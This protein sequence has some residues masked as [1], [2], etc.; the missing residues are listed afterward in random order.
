MPGPSAR[1]LASVFALGVGIAAGMTACSF[2]TDRVC[3]LEARSSL[4]VNVVDAQSGARLDSGSTVV[5]TGSGVHDSITVSAP[6]PASLP[7]ALWLESEVPAG[8]YTVSVHRAAYLDWTRSGVVIKAGECHIAAAAN[9]TAA[10]Q[11]SGS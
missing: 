5:V 8:T 1:P 6:R 2:S 3:T 7:T 9:L 10:L 11:R 4:S